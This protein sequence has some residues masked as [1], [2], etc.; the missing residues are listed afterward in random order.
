MHCG[1]EGARSVGNPRRPWGTR[2]AR[3]ASFVYH[4]V[5]QSEKGLALIAAIR[6]SRNP[7]QPQPRRASPLLRAAWPAA[8]RNFPAD[9]E[10]LHLRCTGFGIAP[11]AAR[12][13]LINCI[14]E[15]CLCAAQP[16]RITAAHT[17]THCTVLYAAIAKS[18][19]FSRHRAE[20][21]DS[22]HTCFSIARTLCGYRTAP[23]FFAPTARKT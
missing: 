23:E 9:A 12:P 18:Q 17:S 3:R 2:P 13:P 7:T 16:A 8:A 21:L 22:R 4:F 19:S 15:K 10:D 11:F 14:P 6:R 20:N 5:C 1:A